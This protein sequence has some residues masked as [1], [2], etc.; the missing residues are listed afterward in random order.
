MSEIQEIPDTVKELRAMNKSLG[1]RGHS[2]HTK[3]GLIED[4]KNHY[5]KTNPRLDPEPEP[6]PVQ[7]ETVAE[8]KE[9]AAKPVAEKKKR[10]PNKWNRFLSEYSKKNGVLIKDAMKN[11]E[12]YDLWLK[13]N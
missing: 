9:V 2:T 13:D 5:L 3:S 4:L 7:T 11:R 10:G 6:E 8:P 12:A 1:I